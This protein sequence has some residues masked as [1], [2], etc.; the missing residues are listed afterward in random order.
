MTDQNTTPGPEAAVTVRLF[1]E[2]G[3]TTGVSQ[4]EVSRPLPARMVAEWLLELG[5]T[6]YLEARAAE[7]EQQL[8]AATDGAG[9]QVEQELR[10]LRRLQNGE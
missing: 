5:T 1:L 7:R 3:D 2:D 8:D 6:M 10:N 4:L 9:D